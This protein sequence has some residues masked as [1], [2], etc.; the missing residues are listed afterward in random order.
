MV[1]NVK[2]IKKSLKILT[3]KFIDYI[4][5]NNFKIELNLENITQKL[6]IKKRRLYDLTN[7]L[8]GIGYL[9]KYKK[10]IMEITPDFLRQILFLKT[11]QITELENR[12]IQKDKKENNS[13]EKQNWK[14][15]EE[16]NDMNLKIQYPNSEEES[17]FKEAFNQV[18]NNFS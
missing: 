3:L 7:V 15:F 14:N 6:N 10:N 12:L 8:E 4:F 5:E 11:K 2:I 16:E 9:K 13:K 1:K 17:I 18:F